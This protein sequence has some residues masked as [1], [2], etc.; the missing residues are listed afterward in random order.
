[1]PRQNLTDEQKAVVCTRYAQTGSLR[2]VA[3]EFGIS[4]MRVK[5]LWDAMPEAER[6]AFRAAVDE[7]RQEAETTIVQSELSDDYLNRVIKARNAAIDEL[8]K[9]LTTERTRRKFTDKNL[10]AAC[11]I[12][13]DLS[14]GAEK[15]PTE[16]A[17]IFMQLNQQIHG[18]INHYYIQ[19]H[20]KQEKTNDPDA[21]TESPGNGPDR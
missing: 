14:T 1:M 20:G 16:G 17:N 4:A 15:P 9:R 3:G 18:E 21:G 8:Y 11:K 19:D 10:I 7:V 12:L 5:R 13:H 2:A 6:R